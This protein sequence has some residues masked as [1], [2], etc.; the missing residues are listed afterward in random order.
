MNIS[1][2]L[3][4]LI[5]TLFLSNTIVSA[6]NTQTYRSKT[7]QRIRKIPSGYD[8]ELGFVTFNNDPVSIWFNIDQK[9]VDQAYSHFG[10]SRAQLK[11][12]KSRYLEE[13]AA[14]YSSADRRATKS[15]YDRKIKDYLSSRGFKLLPGN[16]VAVDIPKMVRRNARN[17]YPITRQF[18]AMAR[19]KGYDSQAAM[20]AATVMV[21]TA[22]D[23]KIPPTRIGKLSTGGVS[24]PLITVTQGWGDCDSKTALLASALKNYS[25]IRMVGVGI[26]GHYLMAVQGVPYQG[27]AFVNF[28]GLPYVLLDPTGPGRFPPGS[29]TQETKEL[30]RNSGNLKIEPL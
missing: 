24:P 23:Y 18:D 25:H 19:L 7:Y 14:A 30:I 26:P 28:D 21:Q 10:Y 6:I 3:L 13:K 22:I 1:R 8:I 12:L 2:L 29:V 9:Q 16:W 20:A 27:D 15:R 5:A 17:L 11:I 4:S